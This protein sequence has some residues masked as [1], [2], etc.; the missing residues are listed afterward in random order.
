MYILKT[1][2]IFSND[3]SARK[4]NIG[5]SLP[6]YR[7]VLKVPLPEGK[8]FDDVEEWRIVVGT[9]EYR[10]RDEDWYRTYQL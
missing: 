4:A 10:M 3:E 2:E 7:A 8:T 5:E 9:L 6:D 1:I